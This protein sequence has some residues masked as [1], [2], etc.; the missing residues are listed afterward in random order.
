MPTREPPGNAVGKATEVDAEPRGLGQL[1][2]SLFTHTSMGV[3][4]AD[5]RGHLIMSNAALQAMLGYSADELAR[6]AFVRFIH[7]D[8][9]ASGQEALDALRTG[10][11][12]TWQHEKRYLA[13]DGRAVWCRVAVLPGQGAGHADVFSL[14]VIEDITRHKEAEKALQASEERYRLLFEENLDGVLMTVPDG[15]VTNANAAACRMLRMT[16]E[17]I[18]AAGRAELLLPDPAHS[19]M[20]EER[21]RIGRLQGE[22]IFVRKD[23][24]T[25]PAEFSSALVPDVPG[26]RRA[27]VIFREV[28]ERERVEQALRESETRYR[29]LFEH[30]P[31]GVVIIDPGT[32]GFL[33]FNEQA[34]LQLCYPRDEFARLT[35]S[36]IDAMETPEET[37]ARMERVMVQG[38]DDFDT[39]QRTRSGEIRHVHVTAQIVEILGR[40]VYHCIWRDITERKQAEEA[41]RRN[42]SYIRTV[43]DNLP[44]GIAVNSV[45]PTV[46]FSYMN[47]RFPELYRTTREALAGQDTFW[48]A[49]YE[50]VE[51]RNALRH[52]VL[53]DC[54]SGDP[55]RMVWMDIPVTR[56][57]QETRFVSAMNA[58]MLGNTMMISMV[59][60]VTHQVRAEKDTEALQAQLAHAQKMESIGRLAGGVAHDFNNM[61]GVILGHVDL[62]IEQVDPGTPL[63]EDLLEVG[64][65]A[66][67]SADLTRQ[68]LAFARKQTV[69]PRVL[70]L[71]QAVT[72]TLKMLQRLI[73]ENISLD[74]KPC[75]ELWPVKI[76]PAQIDQ[77]LANLCVNARD[78]IA[79]VGQITIE[80]GQVVLDRQF[81][82]RHPGCAPGDHVRLAVAD[83]GCGMSRETLSHLF[84]PFFTTKAQGEG[85]GLGLA[86]VYGIVTQNRGFVTVASQPGRGSVFEVFLP[87]YSGPGEAEEADRALPTVTHGWETVLLV[88]DEPAV[89]NVVKRMLQGIGYIVLSAH[90]PRDAI[91]LARLHGDEI[92][93]LVTDVVMPEMNGRELAKRLSSMNPELKCLFISGYSEEVIGHEQILDAGVH[94]VQKPFTVKTLAA[95]VRMV[96]DGE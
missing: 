94:F 6:V 53:E 33:E 10:R 80:T 39:R 73:G 11:I 49:V 79:G 88:E 64:K 56:Q 58:P 83:D 23:G 74:W 91:R 87:R 36:D 13:K 2:S 96:L 37:R 70:D 5:G 77:V 47:D 8:D 4:V 7:P 85:T 3:G 60:D 93:L 62:A 76:D 28:T 44:I 21:D 78:A 41:L 31:D 38:S 17:E 66:E 71:N 24:S 52:R 1:F 34:H 57:G 9:A 27:F 46:S 61:L 22:A 35:L 18:C 45:D 48:E 65:A 89:L 72:G 84:E 81:C 15:T 55:D 25:F 82:I 29:S 90:G 40:R 14:V 68:L 92:D 26:G 43:M 16:V 30:S 42:E 69:S 54:A 86:T 12:S 50:D 19:C 32:A 51:F 75:A 20:I 67:R 95:R 59:W 63:H